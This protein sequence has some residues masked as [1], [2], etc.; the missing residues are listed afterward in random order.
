MGAPTN[1]LLDAN[2][3]SWADEAALVYTIMP[4]VT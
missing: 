2:S 1:L 3:I 4:S